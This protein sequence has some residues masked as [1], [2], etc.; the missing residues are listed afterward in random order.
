MIPKVIHFCWFGGK[1]K[2]RLIKDCI[3]SWRRH[4]PEYKMIEWNEK[5][6]DLSHPFVKEAYRLKK[7][8][9]ICVY[10]L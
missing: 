7:W 4:L 10:L 3:E 5:N 6:S 2:P 9:I 8:A 1:R